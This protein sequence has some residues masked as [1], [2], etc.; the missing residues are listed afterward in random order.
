MFPLLYQSL[1]LTLLT[2]VFVCEKENQN[3]VRIQIQFIK[4]KIQHKIQSFRLA[5]SNVQPIRALKTSVGL[6]YAKISL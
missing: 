1:L 6:Y 5:F 4:E 3:M 2:N